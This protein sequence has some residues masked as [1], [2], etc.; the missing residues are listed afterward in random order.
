LLGVNWFITGVLL[1]FAPFSTSTA[2]VLEDRALVDALRAGGYSIYFRHQATDWSQ[3]DHVRKHGDWLSCDGSKIRQLSDTGREAARRTGAAMRRLGVAVSRVIASPYCRTMETASLL[4]F[5]QPEPS[6]SVMNMRV[7]HFFG[8]EAAIVKT[9]QALLASPVE[10]GANV[11]IVAHG[12][13]A[14]LATPVYPSEGEA[15]I[16]RADGSGSFDFI[17]RLTA[18]K[19]IELANNEQGQ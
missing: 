18:A 16:F 7:A 9:A 13:V 12:N 1:C 3:D 8:G 17:G 2:Q 14:R 10:K 4:G 15:A 19:W 5:G 6:S 11:V